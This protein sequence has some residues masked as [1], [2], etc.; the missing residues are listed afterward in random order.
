MIQYGSVMRGY[1]SIDDELFDDVA[2]LTEWFDRSYEWI[3]TLDP[4]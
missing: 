3:G 4:K 1:V 2:A